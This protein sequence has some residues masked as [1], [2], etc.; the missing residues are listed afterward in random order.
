MLENPSSMI[1]T[2]INATDS[3]SLSFAGGTIVIA[4][5]TRPCPL[6]SERWSL[7]LFFLNSGTDCPKTPLMAW[8]SNISFRLGPFPRTT[9]LRSCI[10]QPRRQGDTPKWCQVA[11][12]IVAITRGWCWVKYYWSSTRGSAG[13][14]D[15]LLNQAAGNA[16]SFALGIGFPF[17]HLTTPRN[18]W[19]YVPNE[20]QNDSW[21]RS[22][23]GSKFYM[24]SGE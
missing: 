1:F 21:G 20:S 11:G 17:P 6:G 15:I 14:Q 4:Y 5:S 23:I 16:I 8:T 13:D 7:E 18:F 22:I 3:P 19:N 24:I 9:L 10:A 2:A 12:H